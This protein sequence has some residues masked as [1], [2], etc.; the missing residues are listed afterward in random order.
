V[1]A[2]DRRLIRGLLAASLILASAF[3]AIAARAMPAHH[4]GTGSAAL[5]AAGMFGYG[6][7]GFWRAAR[8]M[9]RGEWGQR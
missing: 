3:L 8:K 2:T 1:T 7:V 6:A 5:T 4:W 9:A